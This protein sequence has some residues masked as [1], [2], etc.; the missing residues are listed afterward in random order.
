MNFKILGFIFKLLIE[1]K[2]RKQRAG[3]SQFSNKV[4]LNLLYLITPDFSWESS[5][6]GNRRK[7]KL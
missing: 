5:A 7:Y 1:A 2:P 3:M 4:V 6:A